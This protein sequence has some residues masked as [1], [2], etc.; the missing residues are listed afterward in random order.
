MEHK[1]IKQFQC[2]YF[3]C[4]SRIFNWVLLKSGSVQDPPMKK[5]IGIAQVADDRLKTAKDRPIMSAKNTL[6]RAVRDPAF[7]K[8]QTLPLCLAHLTTQLWQSCKPFAYWVDRTPG[9]IFCRKCC[10]D[11]EQW[12]QTPQS[13]QYW[14]SWLH[15]AGYLVT[16]DYIV[17]SS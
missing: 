11:Q 9:I 12:L 1:Q 14:P 2:H 15:Q 4:I 6:S 8:S 13:K 17:K 16:H 3:Y 7:W 5:T 10:R